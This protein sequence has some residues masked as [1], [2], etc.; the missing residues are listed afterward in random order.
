MK[1]DA[2]KTE[3]AKKL[4]EESDDFGD[5]PSDIN[6]MSKLEITPKT[7]EIKSTPHNLKLILENDINLVGKVAYNDFSFRTVLL[8]SMP[9]RSIKQGVTWN[10]TDDSCLRNYLSNVYGVKGQ[11]VIYDACAEVLPATISTRFV[12]ISRLKSGMEHR[13]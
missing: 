1:D 7:G 5:V 12:T 9:W 10:D 8:D 6:W 11:Q 2:V 13:G 3:L 4:L